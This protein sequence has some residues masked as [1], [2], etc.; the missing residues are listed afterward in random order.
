MP[1]YC[2]GLQK[3]ILILFSRKFLVNE[4][5][6]VVPDEYICII[7]LFIKMHSQV[8]VVRWLLLL[9]VM[10]GHTLFI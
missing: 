8:Q 6:T 2:L 7:F 4:I 1:K 9:I 5:G 3:Y 10:H